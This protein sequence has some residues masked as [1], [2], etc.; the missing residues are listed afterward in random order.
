MPTATNPFIDA[1]E[2]EAARRELPERVFQ[3]EYLAEFL[4]DSAVFRRIR[5]SATATAQAYKDYNLGHEYVMGVDLARYNDFTV[6]CIIDVTLQELC[7]IDR[8]NQVSW[9][10]QIERIKAAAKKFDVSRINVDK[11]GVGDPIVEQL[12]KE[13]PSIVKPWG[14]VVKSRIIEGAKDKVSSRVEYRV[15]R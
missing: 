4:E 12:Q 1:D 14:A 8:F 5:E 2:I 6:I 7:Y 10:M 9:E 13:I 3:Q 15:G 11:T